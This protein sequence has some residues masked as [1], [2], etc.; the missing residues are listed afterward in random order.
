MN[1]GAL[2]TCIAVFLFWSV[3]WIPLFAPLVYAPLPY[4]PVILPDNFTAYTTYTL[5]DA[6]AEY[7]A[8]QFTEKGDVLKVETYQDKM[9]NSTFGYRHRQDYSG[10][11]CNFHVHSVVTGYSDK[12]EPQGDVYPSLEMPGCSAA[13]AFRGL[14]ITFIILPFLSLC[15]GA[16]PESIKNAQSHHKNYLEQFE[17]IGGGDPRGADYSVPP[18][19]SPSVSSSNRFAPPPYQESGHTLDIPDLSSPPPVP[20]PPVGVIV[21]HD[22]R[23]EFHDDNREPGP[24][25]AYLYQ[26]PPVPPRQPRLPRRYLPMANQRQAQL[27]HESETN[28]LRTAIFDTAVGMFFAVLALGIALGSLGTM[29]GFVN[30]SGFGE[31]RQLQW[32]VWLYL[33]TVGTYVLM[34]LVEIAWVLYPLHVVVQ[35]YLRE[36]DSASWRVLIQRRRY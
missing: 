2:S 23:I 28:S 1:P 18:P 11:T 27:Y 33:S 26:P 3:W 36:V 13:V 4:T 16:P 31:S 12:G 17:M 24:P 29:F 25:P 19:E 32:P 9:R 20:P 7:G 14:L 8:W 5:L 15:L 10:V 35:R 6:H 34:V 22:G 21:H 30:D